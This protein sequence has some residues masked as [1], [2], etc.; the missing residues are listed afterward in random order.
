MAAEA[1]PHMLAHWTFPWFAEAPCNPKL[2][3][4]EWLVLLKT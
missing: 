3:L 2:V 1:E 4:V